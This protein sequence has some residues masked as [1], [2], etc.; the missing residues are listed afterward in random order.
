MLSRCSFLTARM[1]ESKIES[2]ESVESNFVCHQLTSLSTSASTHYSTVD[3]DAVRSRIS[4]KLVDYLV[5]LVTHSSL[6]QLR[7][8]SHHYVKNQYI[9]QQPNAFSQRR[10]MGRNLGPKRPQ[11]S[12]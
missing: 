8:P 5:I 2:V 12:L 9:L 3:I 10:P 6:L 7:A 1:H 11:E 4:N